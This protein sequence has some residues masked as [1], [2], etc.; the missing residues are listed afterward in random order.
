MENE[1]NQHLH[2]LSFLSFETVYFK[3]FP[4]IW[5]T[6]NIVVVI[7]KQKLGFNQRRYI[8]QQ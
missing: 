5:S 7:L 8:L 1:Q 3:V 4:I 2:A 6:D